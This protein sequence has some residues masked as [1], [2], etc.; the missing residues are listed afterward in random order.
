MNTL[1]PIIMITSSAT[2]NLRKGSGPI[3]MSLP[4]YI[5]KPPASLL[6]DDNNVPSVSANS[7]TGGSTVLVMKIAVGRDGL[8][9]AIKL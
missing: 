9:A 1:S 4:K 6:E 3:K 5:G 7:A 2:E 8:P